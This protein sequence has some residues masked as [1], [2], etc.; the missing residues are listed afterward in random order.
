MRTVI[1][2][3]NIRE[4]TFSSRKARRLR[5]NIVFYIVLSVV[6]VFM[7]LPTFVMLTS[8]VKTYEEYYSLQF[9][10]F[11][12]VWAFDNYV[13]V[14]SSNDDL[15]RWLGNTLF[16]ILSNTV[17]CT[18]S[19]IF[20]A[21]GFAKFRCKVADGVFMVL[22]CTMMIPWAVTMIPSY[23]IWAK[24]GLTNTF[25][26]L[27]L[28]SIGGSA[29]YTFMFKQNMRGIPN[30]ITEAAEIDGCGK[31]GIFTHIVLPLSKAI[32]FTAIILAFNASWSD[33]FWPFLV[34]K[35][36]SVYTVIVEIFSI[37][38]SI[39][40]DQVLIL[41]AFAII[42]PAV[43]FMIFQKNIMQGISD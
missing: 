39:A 36:R 22:L 35:D 33:F 41:L 21:Y 31:I 25:V 34:L 43:L 27:V 14:F 42:P 32:I 7:L 38:T 11:S 29:Y 17:I 16:L 30:E 26:P 6:G 15:F 28:P 19:T 9:R 8:S 3:E 10:F 40:Q 20:V 24:L 23:I 37:K 4:K 18:V 2:M 1:D 5:K 13:R 12:E